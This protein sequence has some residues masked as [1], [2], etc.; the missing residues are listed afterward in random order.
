MDAG[1]D[2]GLDT[3]LPPMPSEAELLAAMEQDDRDVAAR[4]IFP[5][6]DVD[7]AVARMMARRD[8]QA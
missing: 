5:L 2:D 3:D 1:P 4:K 8:K 7:A 6:A